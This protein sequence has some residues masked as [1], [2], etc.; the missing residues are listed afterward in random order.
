MRNGKRL[1]KNDPLVYSGEKAKRKGE[2][3]EKQPKWAF[4]LVAN[5]KRRSYRLI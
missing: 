2:A 3:N 5:K 4:S 1:F